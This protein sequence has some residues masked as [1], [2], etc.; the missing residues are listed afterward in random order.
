M[1][2][3][4]NKDS[5]ATDEQL[6]AYL[7]GELETEAARQLDQRLA[8][9]PQ[10]QQRLQQ[11]QRA[12]DM[13]DELPRTDV[14]ERFTQ[15][16]IEMVAVSIADHADET[17][18]SSARR[19]KLV[20]LAG[21]ILSIAALVAGY[22]VVGSVLDSPNRQLVEDLRVIEN[23]D[24]YRAADDIDFLRALEREGLFTGDLDAASLDVGE[25]DDEH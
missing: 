5:S 7:D 10:L 25:L 15:T 2:E 20:W 17:S 8:N 16:T 18:Q 24:A 1:N 13:L 3:S 4:S 11:H 23:I 12:W 22:S 19:S 9:E 21:G 6:I 14:G